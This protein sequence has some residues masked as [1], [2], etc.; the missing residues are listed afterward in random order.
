MVSGLTQH[1]CVIQQLLNPRHRKPGYQCTNVLRANRKGQ[2]VTL[3]SGGD[4]GQTWSTIMGI[5]KMFSWQGLWNMMLGS[6]SLG[7]RGRFH[8]NLA[9][10]QRT[11][12][13][14]KPSWSLPG[15]PS[16]LF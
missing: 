7:L 11:L 6:A 4:S 16:V 14:H 9:L 13:N 10:Y 5:G 8:P 15:R 1:H 12:V 2:G 3:E